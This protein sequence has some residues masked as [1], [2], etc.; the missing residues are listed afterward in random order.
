MSRPIV[1]A[2]MASIVER[3]RP[4][5]HDRDHAHIQSD[6]C[7]LKKRSE[8]GDGGLGGHGNH[9]SEAR[10]GRSD[11]ADLVWLALDPG[12][13]NVDRCRVQTRDG[14]GGPHVET[15]VGLVHV[16]L[17]DRH[18]IHSRVNHRQDDKTGLGK[19]DPRDL[20][21]LNRRQ[22]TRRADPRAAVIETPRRKPQA[23]RA[24]AGPLRCGAPAG[25]LRRFPTP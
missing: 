25:R 15:P 8:A 16:H 11:Q 9:G 10:A 18:R 1:R 20:D 13:G 6:Q 14:P 19:E 22:T 12:I 24:E 17:S 3:L 21:V 7:E 5:M 4:R 2:R 23:E